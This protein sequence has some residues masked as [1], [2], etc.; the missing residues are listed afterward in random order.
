MVHVSSGVNRFVKREIEREKVKEK[1]AALIFLGPEGSVT[2]GQRSG[3]MT[4]FR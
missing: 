3:F 4:L 2:A 1:D